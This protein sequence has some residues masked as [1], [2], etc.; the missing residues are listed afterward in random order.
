MPCVHH[1]DSHTPTLT[2]NRVVMYMR[3]RTYDRCTP[4]RTRNN[5]RAWSLHYLNG[6]AVPYR[7]PYAPSPHSQPTTRRCVR[8]RA[9]G[10]YHSTHKSVHEH[11]VGKYLAG[12]TVRRLRGTHRNRR[13][14]GRQY[15]NTQLVGWPSKPWACR[16]AGCMHER[17]R[18]ATTTMPMHTDSMDVDTSRSMRHIHRCMVRALVQVTTPTHD[19]SHR[20][21][22]PHPLPPTHT[23]PPT[24]TPSHPT[25]YA[26]HKT[27][28]YHLHHAR[29]S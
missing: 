23:H 11:M 22:P 7:Q 18:S 13:A 1:T 6:K 9:S 25:T 24:R 5:T 14:D 21:L 12:Y 15:A 3:G 2:A 8:E 16:P 29:T 28:A 4:L 27:H 20:Q 17:T 10:T 19:I 26:I